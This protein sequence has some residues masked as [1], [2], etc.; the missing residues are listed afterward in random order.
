MQDWLRAFHGQNQPLPALEIALK[1]ALGLLVG[2]EREWSNKDVE[3]R[4]FAMTALLGL[5]GAQL[6]PAAAE[7]ASMLS[8]TG[9]GSLTI[10]VVHERL[11][12]L[13]A[14]ETYVRGHFWKHSGLALAFPPMI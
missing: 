8:A 9:L 14:L 7:L 4:T 11:I 5:I 2:F 12:E 1:I 10:P 13:L 6:D 3:A